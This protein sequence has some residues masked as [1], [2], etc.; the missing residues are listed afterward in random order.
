MKNFLY[1]SL[2]VLFSLSILGCAAEEKKVPAS[3]KEIAIDGYKLTFEILPNK[4]FLD[5]TQKTDKEL[6]QGE[7]AMLSMDKGMT[8]HF[9]I[10]ITDE[11]TGKEITDATVKVKVI[12]PKK[13]DQIKTTM[14]M[15]NHF[16][17]YFKLAEKGKY[18]ILYWVKIQDK[19]FK[20]G[21]YWEI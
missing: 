2:A 13:E 7:E 6:A 9:F 1:F 4:D 12:T 20:G 19:D 5:K 15:T 8:H 17:H 3:I 16:C 21:F 10:T 11:E 18:E 14:Y